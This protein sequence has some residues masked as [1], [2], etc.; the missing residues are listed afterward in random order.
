MKQAMPHLVGNTAL[1]ERLC[2]DILASTLSH[3]VILEGAKGTG[4]HTVARMCAAA[5][6][7]SQKENAALPIPCLSCAD[8]RKVLEDKSPDVTVLGCEGKATIGVDTVRFLREDVPVLPNDLDFKVYVIED[9]DKM[10]VQAQ[11]ALLLTLE[12][13]PAFVRFFLL[14]ENAG[15]L[16]ETIRSRAPVLRTEPIKREDMDAYLTSHDSRAAQMKLSNP[17]EYAELLLVAGNGIGR[18]LEL[19]DPKVFAPIKENRA[20]AAE[21][22]IAA[23][24]QKGASR[25]LPLL[26]RFSNKRDLLR[27][28]LL[29]LSQAVRDLV[30]LKK[31]EE[32]TLTFWSTPNEAIELC[33]STSL[34]FL[35]R[36]ETAVRRALDENARN[37]NVRLMLIRMVS[38]LE[39]L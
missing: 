16:L 22:V 10:T 21:L 17:K 30:L 28:Q 2:R 26:S 4:K 36:F 20:L 24:R 31:S 9:A 18:A 34:G 39:L 27:D 7:C 12:E 32:I 1:K 35:Y 29:L 25:I 5:L 23:V 19:L 11:N 14:C 3:A 6:A 15:L 38:S 13:P 33:D 37:A 8:C